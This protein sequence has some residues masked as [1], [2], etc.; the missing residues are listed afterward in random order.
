[1]F[2]QTPFTRA[3]LLESGVSPYQW[4]TLRRDGQIREMVRG[5]FVDATLPDT[6]DR[7]IEVVRRVVP[8]D[9]VVARS[10]A[11]WLQG[12]EV[13]DSRGFPATPPVEVVAKQQ[14][15]RPNLSIV[16]A[17]A[18]DDLRPTDIG[19]ISGVRVTTPLRTASDLARFSRRG[20]ALVAVDA[21]LHKGL[22]TKQQL[23]A[24]LPRWVARRGV[25]QL[26]ETI[27]LADPLCQSG[28]ESRM[29]L[30]VIDMGLPRPTL[31]IPIHDLWGVVRFF[32]DLGWRRWR[33]GLEYD[34][35][36]FHGPEQQ[37][38]DESRRA[39]IR[40]RGWTV[41]AFRRDLVFSPGDVFEKAVRALVNEV[42]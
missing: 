37:E 24:E 18:A 10:T 12:L 35:E 5:V 11:G 22:I 1:M 9:V 28:G 33:L 40:S 42:C 14:E 6:L 30:R 7:R 27:D 20:D 34:G 4:R 39:W 15:Q 32:L 3:E 2:P 21:F 19:E 36:E 23:I 41:Q 16:S 25:R 26:R 29:R 38:H 8:A 17:H 13:L 31:Q